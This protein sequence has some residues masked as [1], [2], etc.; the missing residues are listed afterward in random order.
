MVKI[1]ANRNIKEEDRG[2]EKKE[3]MEL[4]DQMELPFLQFH[5]HGRIFSYIQ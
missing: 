5:L 3:Q 4:Q 2:E 1:K